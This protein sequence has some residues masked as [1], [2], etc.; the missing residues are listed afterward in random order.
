MRDWPIAGLYG[1]GMSD[2]PPMSRP[3][4]ESDGRAAARV[5]GL[6]YSTDAKP[7]HQPAAVPAAGSAIADPMATLIRDAATL[8]RIRSLA[9]PAGLDRRLDLP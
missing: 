4:T 1:S 9:D 8:A 3:L 6:R 7:G 5:A 2:D